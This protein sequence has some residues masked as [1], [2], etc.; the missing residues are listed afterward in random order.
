[1]ENSSGG[2]ISSEIKGFSSFYMSFFTFVLLSWELITGVPA[3]VFQVQQVGGDEGVNP[4]PKA[5]RRV[6]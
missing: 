1:M 4:T 6:S 3:A 5:V 2:E